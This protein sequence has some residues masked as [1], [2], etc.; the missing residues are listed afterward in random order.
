MA[1]LV[2]PGV[3]VTITDESF[4][5]SAGQGTVP[6]VVLATAANKFQS[7]STTAVAP[8]TLASN[9]NKL[10]L[11]TSQRDVL[12]T[13]GNPTFY[14]VGGSQQYDNEL[15]EVGLFS[16]YQYLGIA[17]SAYAIRADIDLAQLQ[18]S[19]SAP[20]G[21]AT[22]GDYWL[23]L[24]QT[25]WGIFRA[26]GN[27]NSA[28]AWA[29]RTPTV[30]STATNLE[31]VVQGQRTPKITSASAGVITVS[32]SIVINNR[33]VQVTV[34]DS[35]STVVSKINNNAN[36]FNLGITAT[37]FV[38]S[39]KYALDQSDYG[40]VF[41]LRLVSR[42]IN[43]EI[44]LDG[45]TPSV[46]TNL[47]L[48]ATPINTIAPADSFGNESDYTV[49]T[50]SVD[51][52]GVRLNSVWEKIVLTTSTN[53]RSWWFKVGSIDGAAYPG[54]GWRAA[55]PRVITGT[56]SNPTFTPGEICDIKI[57]T[58]PI[59]SITVPAAISPATTATVTQMVSAINTVLESNTL[60]ALATVYSVG[61]NRYLR[62]TNYDGTD[63]WFNDDSLQNGLATPWKD[64][65]INPTQTYYASVTG[66]VA[67][68]TYTAATLRTASAVAA[69]SGTGYTVGDILTVSGGVFSQASQL[70]VTALQVVNAVQS[71]GGSNYN[72]NDT[73]TFSGPNF[74]TPTI[75]R[76]TSVSGNVITGFDI[77][78]PGQYTGGSVPTNPVSATSTSGS[79]VNATVN[80][81]WGVGTVTVLTAG[82]YS[83]YPTNPASVTGGLG[84]S[85]TFTLTSTFNTSDTFTINVGSGPT[86]INVPAA[87]NN[88]LSGV[89]AAINAAFPNGPIVASA[90]TDAKLKLTNLNNTSFTLEDVSG[91]PLNDSGIKVGYVF[92][93]S[94]TYQGYAP[95]LT[96]P[97]DLSQLAPNNVW[98]NT[99]P[100]DRGANFV[101]KRYLNG[102]WVNMN[103]TPNTG[104]VPMYSSDAFADAGFGANKQIGS[105][106]V[107]YNA[108]G[109][110]PA[111]ATHSLYTWNG[112][113]WAA[114]EYSPSVLPPTGP[115]EE[116]TL[117][118]STA[119]QYDIMVSDGQIWK[120]YRSFYPGTDTFGPTLSS[121]QPFE[122][123]TGTPLVDNDIWVDTSVTNQFVAYRF[124]ATNQL[125]RM[126]DNADHTSPAG[127][128]FADVRPNTTG[129]ASG[130]TLI[131]DM[132]LSNY[133]D[134]DA[135]DASLYPAGMLVLNTR[136]S[137]N[138]VKQWN[139]NYFPFLPAGSNGRWVTASGNASDGTP[140][141]GYKAQRQM[142]V[143]ALQSA[144]VANQDAR[145]ETTYF[146]LLATPGYPECI[147]EMVTLNTDKKDI[148]FIIGDTPARLRPDGTTIQN[149]ATNANNAATNGDD[150]LI[151]SNPYVGL[152]YPWALSTNLDGS[153]V[154]VPPS[155]MALRTY[156]YN[157][158][159]SYPWFAPAGFNRGLVTGV[160][161]VGYL[162]TDGTY[163]PV[164]LNQGQRD[165]MYQNRINPIAYIPNR[166]LV[167]YGQKTLN[168]VA[169]ALDRVN[170][171]RLINYLKYQL[172]NL[173]KPFLFEPNDGQ[174]RQA[175]TATFNSFMGS[176]AGLRALY[177]FAVVCDESNNTPLRI[178]QN[179]LWIDVAIK[180]EKAIEF[181]YIPIR[182]LNT[183]DPLPNGGQNPTA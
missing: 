47:G 42:D 110:N 3:S 29:G 2:S 30:I 39:E 86:T 38:R 12:Q 171:A 26:N 60:N 104:T 57:G 128:V 141:I 6:L 75:I 150:G 74:V 170:V 8:G 53:T 172:D 154:F 79:G 71:N 99:T 19:A 13:F 124:D 119:L 113:A 176:L 23:D 88:S 136:Y 7:G 4:Y 28:Y 52:N 166:G 164:T 49:D 17:N 33:E 16:L 81:T 180:P 181:I 73:L 129:L 1:T 18:P 155:M 174:T 126:I 151:T 55:E 44:D 135:P 123:S 25:S 97:N 146:N 112:T 54:W 31:T 116:G 95:S 133:V 142:V 144:L 40:D 165:V 70:T 105:I 36:V 43:L 41:N 59:V 87:P 34:G 22:S 11:M 107:R 78:Q 134:E 127:I 84:A 167:V 10:Y 82:V 158:Q 69:G 64:A 50:V 14:S 130:S 143:R 111:E 169:S 45:S 160:T 108:T 32:G 46:L 178:D 138:N 161:S 9:A 115:P 109:A 182:I 132:V 63:T 62:V 175:V 35:I 5:A 163:Q 147:D 177:D 85:A 122:Q 148:A 156:A 67:N 83:T 152:Y 91:T 77:V 100:T 114:L 61:N 139:S 96:V 48:N 76:V 56:V 72:I 121:T 159:V 103:R 68:P 153:E 24:N 120:G 98:I 93:R 102:A 15:N 140:Y 51:S 65:G 94:L 137:T 101:V 20:V 66:T 117:W 118:Y 58:A 80:L 179:Q 168:P 162:E 125:W 92:G 131:D 89:V 106:Y 157:D 149:W 173:A 183:G 90:T 21:S 37:T 27:P 145:A